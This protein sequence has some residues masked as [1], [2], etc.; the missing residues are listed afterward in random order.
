[1]K[2]ELGFYDS[3][4]AYAWAEDAEAWQHTGMAPIG[5][6]WRVLN[7]GDAAHTDVRARLVAKQFRTQGWDSVFA[8]TPPITHCRNEKKRFEAATAEVDANRLQARV[9]ACTLPR[10]TRLLRAARKM[11]CLA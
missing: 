8:A 1:M 2:E 10:F 4:L 6:R 5:A 11:F 9:L 7:Q 3:M